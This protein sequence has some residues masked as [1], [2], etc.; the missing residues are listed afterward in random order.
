MMIKANRNIVNYDR[1]ILILTR[2]RNKRKNSTD[3]IEHGF[4][5]ALDEAIMMFQAYKNLV[6]RERK[7]DEE[8]RSGRK[9]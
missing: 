3:P 1:D 2:E 9:S 5:E 8:R 7:Q 6:E 4:Y